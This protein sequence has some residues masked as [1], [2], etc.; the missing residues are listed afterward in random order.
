MKKQMESKSL[1][2]YWWLKILQKYKIL[3]L[4]TILLKKL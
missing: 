3:N 1:I 4:T 2:V